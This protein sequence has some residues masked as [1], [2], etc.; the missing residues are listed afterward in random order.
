MI[1]SKYFDII[2]ISISQETT[3][4]KEQYKGSKNVGI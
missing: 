1:Y 3:P 2:G 4:K